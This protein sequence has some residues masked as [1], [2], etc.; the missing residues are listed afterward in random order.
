MGAISHVLGILEKFGEMSGLKANPSK[1][2]IYLGGADEAHQ[3][4]ILQATGF[5]KGELPF[6]YLRVPLAATRLIYRM[7][8]PLVQRVIA[9]LQHWSTKS[10]SCAGPKQ[11]IELFI[12]GIHGF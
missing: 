5:S 10:L 8:Q 11:L 2:C 9:Q 3:G 4:Q 1:S 7:F 6:T 12:F